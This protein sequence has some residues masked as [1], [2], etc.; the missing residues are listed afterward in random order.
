MTKKLDPWK[1]EARNTLREILKPGDVIHCIL[2]HVSRTGMN[3]RISLLVSRPD[4]GFRGLD[5]LA[6]KAGVA[7]LANKG[8]GLVIGGCG[9]DM[10]FQLVY[11]L[12]R[13]LYP[14]GFGCAGER[15]RS[16][17]HNNGD[18]D[19]TPHY[20]GT[21]RNS[22]EVGKDLKPYRHWHRDGGYA[23]RHNWL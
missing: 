1:T 10:G 12:G 5:S 9:M 11:N 18:K 17:D 22:D 2:R 16:N 21:P 7:K 15:C 8:E 14:E 6:S 4:G 19:Y 3:R 13:I 23:F 20:D